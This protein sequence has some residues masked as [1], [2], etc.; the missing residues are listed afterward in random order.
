MDENLPIWG[1]RVEESDTREQSP[2]FNRPQNDSELFSGRLN[3][4][5]GNEQLSY[6]MM[7]PMNTAMGESS[8]RVGRQNNLLGYL[9]T[10]NFQNK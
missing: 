4:Q 3:V 9:L 1:G 10:E 5:E 6:K 2:N 7:N 8:E